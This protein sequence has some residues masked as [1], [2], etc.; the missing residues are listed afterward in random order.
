MVVSPWVLL[1]RALC[2]RRTRA[3]V[4]FRSALIAVQFLT[5][6]P[7]RLEPPPARREVG[8]SLLW[9]PVVGL[10][11]G[12]LVWV[13][14]ILLSP[15]ATPL[16]AALVL[17]IWVSS[18]GALHLDGLA[19]TADAWVG[20]HGDRK[21]MLAI[22]KDPYSG[23]IAVAAVVCLLLLKFGALAALREG[24]GVSWS[25]LHFACGCILP[26]LLARAAVPVLFAHT[27][28][29]RTRGIGA[30][31]AQ[32]QSRPGGRWVAGLTALAVI[33]VCGRYGL[34]ATAAAAA[35]YLLM[36]RAF[37]RRL[38]GITGD[39]AGAMIE[40][41]EVLTLLALASS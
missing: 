41:I 25:Q 7:I 10:L 11:L 5:C 24:R 40:L 16:A 32:Y 22:M 1:G 6:W 34:V 13:A 33:V 26:P 17:V 30:D 14:A 19:D 20:G 21:R 31:L 38:G 29:I 4:F 36:R 35:S 28:Y 9:Y 12:L 37:I 39:C 8:L 15:L 27:P 2:P 23:P 18:T 3:D